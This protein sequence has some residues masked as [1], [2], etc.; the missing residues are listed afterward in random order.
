MS[1]WIEILIAWAVISPFASCAIG[2]WLHER[3]G[4]PKFEKHSAPLVMTDRGVRG[5]L[6]FAFTL[7]GELTTDLVPSG[8]DPKHAAQ[9]RSRREGKNYGA[10]RV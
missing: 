4:P 9:E 6:R 10:R 8:I 5:P 1:H 3:F 7:D 2:Y